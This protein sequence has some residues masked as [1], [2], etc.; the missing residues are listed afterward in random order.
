MVRG[1]DL[2]MAYYLVRAKPKANLAELK[3]KLDTGQISVLNPFGREMQQCLMNA[4]LDADGFATWEENCYCTP[5]LKQEREVLDLYF[6][7]L[8]TETL[9]KG[10]AW[11][12]I[13]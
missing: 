10:E 1:S 3:Q 8:T 6:S 5:P 7:D 13:A 11:A 2:A 9:N 4:K 12:Q